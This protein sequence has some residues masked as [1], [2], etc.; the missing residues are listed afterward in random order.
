MS[1]HSG[2]GLLVSPSG[3]IRAKR[4]GVTCPKSVMLPFA[5]PG[6]EFALDLHRAVFLENLLHDT[7]FARRGD[8]TGP[9]V[10]SSLSLVWA[11]LLR[12]CSSEL[13]RAEQNPSPNLEPAPVWPASFLEGALNKDEPLSWLI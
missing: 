12:G 3:E 11:S 6:P 2:H 7:A 1:F 10:W 13:A 5:H 8:D 9:S 4:G